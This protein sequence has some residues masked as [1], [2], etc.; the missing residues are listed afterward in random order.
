[1]GSKWEDG[2]SGGLF[3]LSTPWFVDKPRGHMAVLQNG[4]AIWVLE[5]NPWES[6]GVGI[7]RLEPLEGNHKVVEMVAK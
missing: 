4:F 5:I 2:F 7:N 1:M 3:D 6:T